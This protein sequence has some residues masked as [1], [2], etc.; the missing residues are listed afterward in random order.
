MKLVSHS[1]AV[2]LVVVG[3]SLVV[4]VLLS[5]GSAGTVTPG[6]AM[7]LLFDMSAGADIPGTAS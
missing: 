1:G 7:G 3:R 2:G 6:A 5:A 4:S